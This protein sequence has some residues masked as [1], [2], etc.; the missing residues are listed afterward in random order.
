[1]AGS[2]GVL[3][4]LPPGATWIDM[5]SSSPRAGQVLTAAANARG[6][7]GQDHVGRARQR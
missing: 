4:A 5:T 3:A 7:D 1:M 2:G 6:I